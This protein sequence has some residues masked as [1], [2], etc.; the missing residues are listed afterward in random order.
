[1]L[2]VSHYNIWIG[3]TALFVTGIIP[4]SYWIVRLNFFWHENNGSFRTMPC[5]SCVCQQLHKKRLEKSI[6]SKKVIEVEEDSTSNNDGIPMNSNDTS[7]NENT[8]NESKISYRKMHPKTDLVVKKK[9]PKI[10]ESSD[11]QNHKQNIN[12]ITNNNGSDK[13]QVKQTLLKGIIRDDDSLFPISLPP[14]TANEND[15]IDNIHLDEEAN[16]GLPITANISSSDQ[17]CNIC[18]EEYMVGEDIGW[19][20]NDSCHHVFHKKCI[21]EWLVQHQDCPICR[22]KF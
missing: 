1:M 2:G 8:S 15:L 6:I 12:I 3:L 19:S 9:K 7:N 20:K 5:C 17:F 22:N 21:L 10:E 16:I 14:D 13:S 11:K 18:L 4:Y